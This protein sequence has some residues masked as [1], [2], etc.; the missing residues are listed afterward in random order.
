M[1]QLVTA[2]VATNLYWLGRN[3][4]RAKQMLYKISKAYDLIIDV[5]R[6]AG[7][8]LFQ[9]FDIKLEYSDSVDF[10]QQAIMGE[11]SS[12]ILEIMTNARESAIICRHR[13]DSEAFGEMIELHAL[14]D[15]L[16]KTDIEID[17]KLIDKAHSLIS[18]IYGALAKREH[19]NN[20]DLFIRMGKLVEEA[21]FRLRFNKDETITM[22]VIDEIDAIVKTLSDEDE[23]STKQ[24]QSQSSDETD[25]I[26][27]INTKINQVIVE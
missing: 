27:A 20:S 3:L 12:N 26:T 22:T 23:E 17:Y 11:H 16:T 24:T 21:D 8:K 15:T 19:T 6:D 9:T 1:D 7:V 14:F 10:L 18:E 25:L 4:E 2:N 13:I 5:D